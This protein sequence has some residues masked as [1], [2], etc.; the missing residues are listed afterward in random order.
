MYG[1]R[2]NQELGV[3]GL[4]ST[5]RQFVERLELLPYPGETVCVTESTFRQTLVKS[6]GRAAH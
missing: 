2:V 1:Y 3:W 5:C 4:P 6:D